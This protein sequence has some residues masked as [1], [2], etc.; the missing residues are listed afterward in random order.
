LYICA[1]KPQDLTS[2]LHHKYC[3]LILFAL[4]FGHTLQAQN[5]TAAGVFDRP[6]VEAGDTFG[7][8]ILVSNTAAKPDRVDFS[9]WRDFLPEDNILRRTTWQRSGDKWISNYTLIIFD[10]INQEL[11]PLAVRLLSGDAILTNPMSL[12]VTPTRVSGDLTELAPIRDIYQE[13]WLWTDFA[14]IGLLILALGGIVFYWLR[15]KKKAARVHT[16]RQ[17]PQVEIP[18]EQVVVTPAHT[19]ALLELARLN[20]EKPWQKGAVKEYYAEL[21]LIIRSY[22]EERYQISAPESTTREIEA[23]LRQTGFPRERM[24]DLRKILDQSDMAKYA[25]DL[26]ADKPHEQYILRSEELIKQTAA[27]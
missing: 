5:A 8:R 4:L 27:Q 26:G 16:Y 7:L 6:A 21:S 11:P 2:A 13:S 14:L 18:V 15:R 24:S 12:M 1:I 9:A 22:L 19:K 3:T 25:Q 23:M 17:R 10:S 20:R